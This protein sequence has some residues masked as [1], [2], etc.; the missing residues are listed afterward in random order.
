MPSYKIVF[1]DIDGTLINEEREIPKE[2]K[3]S[4]KQLKESQIEVVIATGR[5]PYHLKPI[6]EEL[7]IDSYVSFNGSYV[8]YQG[9]LIDEHPIPT[10]TIQRMD[11][12]ARK[13][14]HPLVYLG[15]KEC[16]AS[17]PNHP[18]IVE[19]F[20]LLKIKPPAFDPDF[21]KQNSVYQVMLYCES[22]EEKQY[23]E[24]FSEV[25]FVRW[26]DLSMDVIP[27][28]CSKAT[29]VKSVLDRLGLSPTEAAAFGDALNDREMLSFVGM[30]IAMGNAHEGL[31]PFA[32][33]TTKHV[34]D[35]GILYG[36]QK[37]GLI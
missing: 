14:D 31:K 33:F 8:V 6:A 13:N 18:D 24:H 26:H 12:F 15:N 30:G 5:A 4:I 34:D 1:F 25:N 27:S 16:F 9:K 29:G 21:W 2:T 20:Q 11:E 22:H 10:S 28:E 17:Q 19:T 3:E 7:G 32:D 23:P 36:L 37:I 35:G